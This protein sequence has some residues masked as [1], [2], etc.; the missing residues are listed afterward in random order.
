MNL[1]QTVDR[2]V[3]YPESDNKP[4]GETDLHRDWMVRILEIM[5]YRY[6][7]QRVYV[8]SDLI[9]Y[10]EE[11][12]PTQSVVP[13][14]FVVKDCDPGRRRTFKIWEEGKTP[15]VA[16]EVTSRGS[17]RVDQ[18]WK[19]PIYAQLGI[20]EYFLY[21]PTSD[22]LAPP[23][24]G[25]RLGRKRY[26]RIR[27][28]RRGL[29]ECQSLGITLGLE[30]GELVMRDLATGAVLLTRAEAAEARVAKLE[31]ASEKEKAARLSAEARAVELEAELKRLRGRRKR[32][33][34]S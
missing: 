29:L 24:Q 1:I 32:A 2:I 34:R 20:F 12:D 7:G 17:R 8:A 22:Y 23:L 30:S 31:A 4:M 28:D 3:E 13:D 21:D 14:D 16:F 26:R 27:P 19:P 6:R 10:F 11:G 5:R 25:F 15:D 18:V 33:P 9:V